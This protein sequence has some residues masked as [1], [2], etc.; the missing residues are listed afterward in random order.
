MELA[1]RDIKIDIL[2]RVLEERNKFLID[3]NKEIQSTSKNNTFLV[4]VAEDYSKYYK[5]IKQQ[6][7]EQQNAFE[8]LSK[9][10][11]ETS[12]TIGQTKEALQQSKVQ[13]EQIMTHIQRLRKEIDEII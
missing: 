13:Q 3:K 2:K 8:L 10:I 6:K 9:Y 5:A 11:S 1:K 7:I 4:E 12:K